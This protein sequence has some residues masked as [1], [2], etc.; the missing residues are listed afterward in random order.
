MNNEIENIQIPPLRWQISHLKLLTGL[1][2]SKKNW[3]P[4]FFSLNTQI[5][6]K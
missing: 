1:Q 4:I 5:Q 3:R 6:R 2:L